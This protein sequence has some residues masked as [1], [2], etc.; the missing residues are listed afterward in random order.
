VI[1][2]L[3]V[4]WTKEQKHTRAEKTL[5]FIE[6]FRSQ[7]DELVKQKEQS[8]KKAAEYLERLQHLQADMENLQKM[9]KRQI[10]SVTRQASEG[11]LLKLLP[12]LDALQQA[13]KIAQT[14][15]S[16]SPEEISVGLKMVLKQL[17]EA[18]KSEG[19]DEIPALGG[20]L[21]PQ[22]HEV[23]SFVETSDVP[24]NTVVQE[25]RKGYLLNGKV[26]RP[27]LVV[28]SKPKPSKEQKVGEADSN[29]L[30]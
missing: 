6:Q 23:V 2:G 9:T 20:L 10:D 16:L 5:D 18:L 28:V 15:N 8:D 26:I 27:S 25:V 1:C 17:L 22:R 14:G 21:N 24:E 4:E 3:P 13:T 11:V 12:S 29:S 19:L 7:T 30:P